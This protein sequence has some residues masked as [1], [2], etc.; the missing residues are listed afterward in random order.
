MA[1]A[2][3]KTSG[4]SSS[5]NGRN[6]KGAVFA[7][8]AVAG[9]IFTLAML[10][11]LVI[12]LTPRS[13][14]NL[15]AD[16]V[17]GIVPASFTEVVIQA[18]GP[19]GKQLV[20]AG[21]LLG[22]VLFGGLIA[23]LLVGLWP[24]FETRQELFR[25]IY[26]L[27]VGLWFVFVLAGVPLIGGGLLGAELGPDQ[28]SVLI[29]SF[30]LFQLYGMALGFL[31]GYLVPRTVSRV[32][33][34]YGAS[35]ATT[36]TEI[37]EDE[38]SAVGDKASR[39]RFV[40][41]M[42]GLFVVLVGAAISSNLVKPPANLYRSTLGDL[43]PDGTVEGE[44]TPTESFYQ[45]SKNAFNPKVNATG[46][47]LDISGLVNTPV[48]FDFDGIKKLPV[49]TRYH[50]LTCI[51]NPVGGEYIGN[52]EWRGTPLK[53]ILEQ[54][55][56][57]PG[58]KRLVFTC[59]DGYTDS[60]PLEVALDPRT[61]LA[62][63]MNGKPLTDDHGFPARMLIPDIYGMKNAKWVT[64]ITLVDTD[65]LGF[66]Q[67]QG[68]DNGAQIKTQSSITFPIEADDVKAGQKVTLKG[69]AFAGARGIKKVELS[70]DNGANWAEAT[71]K[72]S[73]SD[74][75]WALW[76]V[77]WNVP[78]GAKNYTLK[79]RATDG[80]GAAQSSSKDEPFPSGS[81]GYHTIN[82]KAL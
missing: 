59:A 5:Y 39:R 78:S 65:Y 46:W 49:Q 10:L 51:S 20:F 41:A 15:I 26:L 11:L 25:N 58:V 7:A 48:S 67:K 52:A 18:I 47:K 24:R 66:W 9:M 54:A 22:Q 12:G 80:T 81:S 33:P 63:E 28:L 42:S 32:V 75:S 3:D 50:T 27:T 44:V 8:G 64:S 71:I 82:I 17:A 56:V 69:I 13:V 68:W 4:Q 31:F 21:V 16:T 45:V 43:R 60:I 62:Y 70:T 73:L 37:E 74:T 2:T 30:V 29:S 23:L 19:L 79:V 53:G 38:E 34:A 61:T 6:H 1:L 14:A 55:G 36:E 57:K 35:G 77:E 40:L 72:P 76:R